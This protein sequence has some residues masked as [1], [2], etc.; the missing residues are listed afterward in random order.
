MACTFA[1]GKSSIGATAAVFVAGRARQS[2]S[3]SNSR[4][5]R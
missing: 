3:G 4:S 2:P 1:T 5:L